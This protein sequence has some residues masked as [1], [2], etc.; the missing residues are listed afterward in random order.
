MEYDTKSHCK[1]L[2]ALH[3][4]LV[5]KYRKQLLKGDVGDFVKQKITEIAERSEFNIEEIEVDKDHIH[6]LLTISPNISVASYVRRIKQSTTQS[7][8]S[9]FKWFKWFKKQF[10]VKK[11]FWSDG[12]FVCSVGNAA[13][14][15]IR[16]YIQEQG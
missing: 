14:D 13:A 5:V 3:L 9:R 12:Y 15:T 2:I 4:I 16:K 1:Y 6:I 7:L 11:T 8:W 10:W